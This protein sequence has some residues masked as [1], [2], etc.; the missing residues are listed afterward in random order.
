MRLVHALPAEPESRRLEKPPYQRQPDLRPRGFQSPL[1][2]AGAPFEMSRKPNS[3]ATLKNLPQ[4]KRKEIFERFEKTPWQE[5]L[6]QLAAE[7]IPCGKSALYEFRAWYESLRPILE[8][9]DFARKFAEALAADKGLELDPARINKVAQTAFEM[10]SVQQ[11]N[12]TLFVEL[13][14]LRA[15]QETNDIKRDAL[16]QRVREYEEKM[17]SVRAALD[18]AN[19]TG[20]LTPEGRAEIERA[21]GAM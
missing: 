6:T 11:Q 8:A 5:L 9:N 1:S 14:R 20:A 13:Q 10:Q 21:M 19:S 4:A 12:P 18:R 2:A 15:R 3:T 7:G 16:G 17:K